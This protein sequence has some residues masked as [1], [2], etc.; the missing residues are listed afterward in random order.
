MP[1][2]KRAKKATAPAAKRPCKY[3]RGEDGYCNKKPRG[4]AA[5]ASPASPAAKGKRP[6]KYGRGADGYCNKKPSSTRTKTGA[7]PGLLDKP[8]T[9]YTNTGRKT[10]T[11]LRKEGTKILTTATEAAVRSQ[12]KRAVEAYK[13]DPEKV[14]GQFAEVV[15]FLGKAGL[16]G[17]AIVFA[18]QLG[19]AGGA[20]AKKDREAIIDRLVF[21]TL[22]KVKSDL[23]RRGQWKPEFSAMLIP[24]YRAFFTTQALR[25]AQSG[26]K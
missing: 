25:I 9:S 15:K 5:P 1:K 14:K 8:L 13:E 24:Q 19:R 3:G 11:T 23:L 16:I 22:N 6:C 20:A 26:G 17:S 7:P 21:D 2:K 18:I 12:V 10:S 4:A